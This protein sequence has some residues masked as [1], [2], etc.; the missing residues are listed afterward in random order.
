MAESTDAG[1]TPDHLV[2][3]RAFEPQ[4]THCHSIL[5]INFDIHEERATTDSNTDSIKFSPT[6]A[7][8]WQR[9]VMVI[10]GGRLG[11][12]TTSGPVELHFTGVIYFQFIQ[13]EFNT[14]HVVE[15]SVPPNTAVWYDH[16]GLDESAGF[17]LRRSN[18]R[19]P[20][21]RSCSV[22]W[23]LPLGVRR[24]TVG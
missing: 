2:L 16:S 22:W 5:E 10:L 8:P 3:W 23:I 6:E 20:R 1:S 14:N 15:T 17:T 7:W 12:P 4:L 21:G 9:I 24:L 18:P 13:A 19:A 11:N